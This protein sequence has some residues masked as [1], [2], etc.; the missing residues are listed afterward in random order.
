MPCIA[1]DQRASGAPR[2]DDGA[3]FGDIRK[4]LTQEGTHMTG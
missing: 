3:R 1:P 4:T 2:L